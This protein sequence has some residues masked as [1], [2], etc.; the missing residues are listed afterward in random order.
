MITGL[1]SGIARGLLRSERRAFARTTEAQRTVAFPRQRFA[2]TVCDG[3][4]GVVEGSLNERH[5]VRNVLAFFLLEYLFL[6]FCPGC[7]ASGG[8]CCWFRHSLYSSASPIG[9]TTSSIRSAMSFSC[10]LLAPSF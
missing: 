3:H 2:F 5:A 6:A 4:N 8:R 1:A 7:A 9:T 10:E